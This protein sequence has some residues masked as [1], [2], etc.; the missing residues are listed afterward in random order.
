MIDS[1]SIF[2]I[3]AALGPA[4][5]TVAGGDKKPSSNRDSKFMA[6]QSRGAHANS[7]TGTPPPPGGEAWM[8]AAHWRGASAPSLLD[9]SA[10]G[11]RRI[12]AEQRRA[13]AARHRPGGAH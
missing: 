13:D 11:H 10:L 3:A 7:D 12:G 5:R 6:Q 9:P 8:D 4:V 1:Y 2:C